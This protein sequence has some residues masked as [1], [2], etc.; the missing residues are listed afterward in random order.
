[1]LPVPRAETILALPLD[2]ECAELKVWPAAGL[3]AIF[4]FHSPKAIDFDV[5][6]RELQGQQPLDLFC[7]FLTTIGRRLG[8]PVL[9]DAEGGDGSHP[10]LGY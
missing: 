10:V 6:L 9:M 7:S 2:A 1:V 5:D 4:R 3:L 8:K